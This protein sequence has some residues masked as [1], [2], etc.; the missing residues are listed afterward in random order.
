MTSLLEHGQHTGEL[1]GVVNRFGL[2][3]V[4]DFQ[5]LLDGQWNMDEFMF[6]RSYGEEEHA[7]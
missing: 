6:S 5:S 1:K 3:E 4:D 2:F 7:N